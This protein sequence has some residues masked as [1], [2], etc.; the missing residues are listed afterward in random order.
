MLFFL[1]LGKSFHNFLLKRWSYQILHTCYSSK[2]VKI[3]HM[4]DLIFCKIVYNYNTIAYRT[5]R[6]CV[7]LITVDNYN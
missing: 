6:A 2:N 4:H 3:I 7:K 1:V 5:A